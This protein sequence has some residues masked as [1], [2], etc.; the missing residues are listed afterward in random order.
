M[1]IKRMV[2]E[3]REKI[4]RKG[5]RYLILGYSMVNRMYLEEKKVISGRRY[6]MI[7]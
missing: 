6:I 5:F 7:L 3:F 2:E 1:I 4:G